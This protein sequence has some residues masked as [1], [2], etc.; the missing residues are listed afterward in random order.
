MSDTQRAVGG[1]L[2]ASTRGA[3][4]DLVVAFNWKLDHADPE[5]F[6]ELFTRDG[7]FAAGPNRRQGHDELQAFAD[8]RTTQEKTSRTMLAQHHLEPADDSLVRGVVQY[9]LFMT[10]GEPVSP[11]TVFAVGEYEDLYRFEDGGW[12]IASRTSRVVFK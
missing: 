7:V 12:R 1:A 9:T 6:A 8:E 3:L 5:G 10:D 11:P 2:D 4:W